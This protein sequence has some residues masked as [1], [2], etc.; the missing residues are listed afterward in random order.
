[1]AGEFLRPVGKLFFFKRYPKIWSVPFQLPPLNDEQILNKL[2]SDFITSRDLDQPENATLKAKSEAAQDYQSLRD[3]LVPTYLK[4]SQRASYYQNRYFLY[5]WMLI[6]GAFVTALSATITIT[7]TNSDAATNNRA[8]WSIITLVVAIVTTAANG[9]LAIQRPLF[10]WYGARRITEELR[11]HYYLYIS[12]LAPYDRANR[13]EILE[14]HVVQIENGTAQLGTNEADTAWASAS[15]EDPEVLKAFI[16]LYRAKRVE[17]QKK[18][19]EERSDEYLIN[20]NFVSFASFMLAGLS[21]ALAAFNTSSTTTVQWIAVLVA[22]FPVLAAFLTSFEKIYGWDRQRTL[23]D[24]AVKRLKENNTI[25]PAAT[26]NAP[27][28]REPYSTIFLEFVTA[29]EDTLKSEM[30]QW[31]KPVLEDK[32]NQEGYS[33]EQEIEKAL[34]KLDNLAPEVRDEIL[35]LVRSGA[36]HAPGGTPAP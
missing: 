18:F 13:V 10:R 16:K 23:Y 15:Y 34:G 22:I 7:L 14:T 11:R 6:F 2:S 25:P 30:E 17:A 29:V 31:G 24:G 26:P 33:A 35:K 12:H 32:R 4:Q 5:Q 9:L 36:P 19:Y 21:T 28:P 20:S 3:L 1:M 8:I 27:E